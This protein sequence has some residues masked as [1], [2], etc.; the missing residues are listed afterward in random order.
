ME[1]SMPL[2]T[3][4]NDSND[5][6]GNQPQDKNKQNDVKQNQNRDNQSKNQPAASTGNDKN[7]QTKKR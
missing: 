5:K 4:R 1:I 2:Q 6:A 3:T 7:A